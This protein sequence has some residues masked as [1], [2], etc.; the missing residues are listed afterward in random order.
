MNTKR[1]WFLLLI[2]LLFSLS[3]VL[4]QTN[5]DFEK[6]NG[7]LVGDLSCDDGGECSDG[8]GLVCGCKDSYD[9]SEPCSGWLSGNDCP[10]SGAE[11][12]GISGCRLFAVE[13]DDLEAVPSGTDCARAY[14]PQRTIFNQQLQKYSHLSET[15]E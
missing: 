4:S 10:G 15:I 14:V 1:G 13:D 12:G 9:C 3:F 7:I 8:L 11:M 6:Y 2:I 5:E